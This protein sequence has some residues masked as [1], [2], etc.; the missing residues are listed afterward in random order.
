MNRLFL[1]E[2]ISKHIQNVLTS[3]Y[4]PGRLAKDRP[5]REYQSSEVSTYL[6]HVGMDGRRR[7]IALSQEVLY[8][9]YIDA[10]HCAYKNAAGLGEV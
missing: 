6:E 7:R 8:A 1:I 4:T 5:S 3:F 9:T 2:E 10:G